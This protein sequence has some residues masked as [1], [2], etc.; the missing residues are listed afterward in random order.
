MSGSGDIPPASNVTDDLI[1]A[2]RS[3]SASEPN[4]ESRAVI[5]IVKVYLILVYY[6]AFIAG[7]VLNI[8]LLYLII[9]YKKLHT[10]SFGISLQI[11]VL[12]LLQLYGIYLFRLVT[13][14]ADEWLF[15]AGLCVATGFIDLFV[16]VARSFLMCVFVIDR[17]LSVF[18]VYFYPRH[19]KKIAITLSVIA[20]I[21]TLLSQLPAFPGLLD[22]Y[23]F[24]MDRLQCAYFA[25]CSQ[26]C[27]IYARCYILVIFVPTT[28][29]PV[30]LY[31]LLYWKV[32]KIKQ[33]GPASV[34][35]VGGENQPVKRDWKAAITFFLLFLTAF[36]LTTPPSVL[37]V[38]FASVAA[39]ISVPSAATYA[40]LAI[41][42]SVSSLL[43]IADPIVIMRHSDVKE[44]LREI[45][46]KLCGRC[47]LGQDQ[48]Q[49][50]D[51]NCPVN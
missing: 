37:I 33:A 36:I 41:L 13:V 10:L 14:A 45:K 9:R 26:S 21:L 6:S 30:V 43:V 20:W 29:V 17:F 48:N 4:V 47:G 1:C 11:V 3:S 51:L 31:T 18:A 28:I 34:A 12:D 32:K 5:L 24:S 22:C 19:D 35:P 7:S 46:T 44:V 42:S 16:R 15:G 39:N 2:A 27:S 40:T 50:R 8:L 49:V 25:R 23:G 38:I